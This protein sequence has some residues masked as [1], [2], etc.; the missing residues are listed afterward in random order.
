MFPSDSSIAPYLFSLSPFY[1][2]LAWLTPALKWG[3]SNG[4]SLPL[5]AKSNSR[6]A[7]DALERSRP[8]NRAEAI[9][10]LL[11]DGQGR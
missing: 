8:Q 10:K 7:T 3:C 4:Q 2:K 1:F 6:L 5:P 11:G 9:I